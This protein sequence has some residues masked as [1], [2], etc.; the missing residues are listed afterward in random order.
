M[1][2]KEIM[3]RDVE[4]LTMQDD[5]R[6]AARKMRDENIGFLPVCD[7]GKKVV[8]TITDRDIVIRMVADNKPTNTAVKDVM[9]REIIACRPEDEIHQAQK[10]MGQ[11]HKSRIMCI[12]NGGRLVGVISLSDI[13]QHEQRTAGQTLREVTTREARP[14]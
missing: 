1:Q 7:D 8:G 12:D 9:T 3:K 13:A 11:H 6:Q 4:C 10:L 5:V 2:C 14:S